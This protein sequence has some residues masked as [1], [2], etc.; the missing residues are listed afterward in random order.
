MDANERRVAKN[1]EF[2]ASPLHSGK[3]FAFATRRRLT[4]AFWDILL[5]VQEYGVDLEK[6]SS[7]GPYVLSSCFYTK[8]FEDV[9]GF[10]GQSIELLLHS[11]HILLFA[12]SKRRVN[13]PMKR[14]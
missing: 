4:S 5:K 6:I 10:L 2:H 9:L 7:R 11:F 14:W 8:E 12:Y 13:M 3:S 1:I